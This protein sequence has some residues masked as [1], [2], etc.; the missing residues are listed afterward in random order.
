[1][2]RGS[3]ASNCSARSPVSLHEKSEPGEEDLERDDRRSCFSLD[4]PSRAAESELDACV[5][6]VRKGIFAGRR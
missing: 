5:G 2:F 6:K 3:S 4:V 1:M